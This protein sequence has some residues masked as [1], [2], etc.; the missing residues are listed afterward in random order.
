[1]QT[2]FDP[3]LPPVPCLPGDFNQVIL[4]MVVNAAHAIADVVGDGSE[5]KGTITVSTS[6]HD[7]WAVVRIADTGTGVAEKHRSR[8]FDPFF[9]T[10]KIGRGTGQGLAI[11]HAVI[12]EK[13]G[14]TL[15]FET[16][17]GKGTTFVIRLPLQ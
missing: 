9:T 4:N 8:I 17:T 6:R 1:M 5:K 12:V 2:N 7:G 16:E 3:D 13:H 15:T 10:K 11:A 14:G